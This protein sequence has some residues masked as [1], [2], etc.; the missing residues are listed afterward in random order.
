VAVSPNDDSALSAAL[1]HTPETQEGQL[2]LYDLAVALTEMVRCAVATVPGADAG[3][4][5]VASA[6]TQGVHGSTSASVA[7]LDAVQH[8]VSEGP[9]VSALNDP[10]GG[11]AVVVAA[12]LA[13][14]DAARWPQFARSAVEHGFPAALSL[15]LPAAA[16]VG[17]ALNLYG[18]QV[19]SFEPGA[20]VLADMF[21]GH[22]A[23]LLFGEA[24]ADGSPGQRAE[25]LSSEVEHE[26]RRQ[27]DRPTES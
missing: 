4:I 1:S 12:D 23:H 9:C 8:S 26:L 22:L 10:L 11:R 27:L 19:A 18:R 17:A 15:Q 7:E 5:S 3:G 24:A 14:S 20:L 21:V 16:G 2:A 6:S 25:A 13:G